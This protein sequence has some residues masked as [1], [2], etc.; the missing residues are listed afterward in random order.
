ME[1]RAREVDFLL[2]LREEILPVL[3]I[4]GLTDS[5]KAAHEKAGG[6]VTIVA[7]HEDGKADYSAEVGALSSGGG[8]LLV[9]A[10][11]LDQG[12]KGIIQAS[13]DTGA[14]DKFMLPDGMV[15][16]SLAAA[17]GEDINGSFGT[18][19]GTDSPGAA[20]MAEITAGKDFSGTDPVVERGL[21]QI[22]GDALSVAPYDEPF[23][24]AEQINRG[25]RASSGDYV[26]LLND[27]TELLA[28]DSVAEMGGLAGKK[29]RLRFTI[30]NADLY[31]FW[32]GEGEEE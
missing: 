31:A 25:V 3:D 23:N 9:V 5:F 16:D 6:S 18:V 19:P 4:Q 28:P 2:A 7:A 11:Y 13:L 24:F 30:E 27:D 32:F 21:R 17:F 20:L 8:D 29:V 22:A 12:G 1:R 10:G 15:G 14:F 26:L